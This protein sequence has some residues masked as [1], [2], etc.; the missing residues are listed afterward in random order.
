MALVVRQCDKDLEDRDSTVLVV[1]LINI[2]KVVELLLMLCLS[3]A[4]DQSANSV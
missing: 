2:A 4:L 3:E 1:W